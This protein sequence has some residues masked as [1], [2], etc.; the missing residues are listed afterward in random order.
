MAKQKWLYGLRLGVLA[1]VTMTSAAVPAATDVFVSVGERGEVSF[2]DFASPQARLITLP[3][4]HTPQSTPFT[5]AQQVEL[6]LRVAGE[7]AEARQAREAA[8]AERARTAKQ[9][10]VNQSATPQ[11]AIEPRA[12]IYPYAFPP[13][14]HRHDRHRKRT[15]P[16]ANP[17]APL[18]QQKIHFKLKD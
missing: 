4:L 7:L 5:S 17:T 16:N 12:A 1:C 18:K 11:P 14:F 8:R 10:L 15:H 13:S 9:A 2:S 6:M 3:E